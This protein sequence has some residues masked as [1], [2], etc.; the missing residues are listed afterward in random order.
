MDV[1]LIKR[2]R[3]ITSLEVF[4]QIYRW[5]VVDGEDWALVADFLPW[6]I[7]ALTQALRFIRLNTCRFCGEN[8]Q[9]VLSLKIV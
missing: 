3:F 4:F 9:I 5:V 8:R 6:V 1:L 2:E 7:L